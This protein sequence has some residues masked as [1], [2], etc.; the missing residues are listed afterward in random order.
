MHKRSLNGGCLGK[1]N[2][3][4]IK[5]K[6]HP[7]LSEVRKTTVETRHYEEGPFR[8]TAGLTMN[9]GNF[10]KYCQYPSG[11]TL[12]HTTTMCLK[13]DPIKIKASVSKKKKSK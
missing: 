4:K 2:Q 13:T 9:Y 7:N 3:C 12:H 10:R 8:Y 6:I 11:V 5:K 1:S